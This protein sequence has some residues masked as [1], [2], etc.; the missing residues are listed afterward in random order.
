ME[1]KLPTNNLTEMFNPQERSPATTLTSPEARRLINETAAAISDDS[2][3][4][5]WVNTDTEN[6]DNDDWCIAE[7]GN[8]L[9]LN[10]NPTEVLY[11]SA[12]SGNNDD[13]AAH[14][15][16][17]TTLEV[18]SRGTLSEFCSGSDTLRSLTLSEAKQLKEAASAALAYHRSASTSQLS[19]VPSESTLRN[20]V[21]TALR[22]KL[23]SSP[24]LANY[25]EQHHRPTSTLKPNRSSGGF[26]GFASLLDL[27]DAMEEHPTILPEENSME[28]KATGTDGEFLYKNRFAAA[29]RDGKLFHPFLPQPTEEEEL[30]R[31]KYV[32]S[33]ANSQGGSFDDC[34]E[35]EIAPVL[36]CSEVSEENRIT[37]RKK[38]EMETT[39]AHHRFVICADTQF[40]ILMDG[41]PMETPNWDKEMDISLRAVAKINSMDPPPRFV[42]VCGDLV[43]TEAS[44]H[45]G[46]KKKALPSWKKML[47]RKECDDIQEQQN[48]DFQRIWSDLK[49]SIALVCLCGNHDVGNRPTVG[50]VGRFNKFFGDDYLGFWT[51]GTYNIMLNNCLFFDPSGAPELYD[52]QLHWLQDRLVYADRHGAGHI[53]VYGHY[54]WFL[55]DEEENMD[56]VTSRSVPPE[57]WGPPGVEFPDFYFHIKKKQRSVALQLFKKYNVKACFS[58]HFHQNLIS[59]TSWGMDMIV[60]GPLSMMLHSD[61]DAATDSDGLGVRVVDVS[62][63][64]FSHKFI[65]L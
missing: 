34:Y 41:T 51:N 6:D 42:T 36:L 58:G 31:R 33:Q 38:S 29:Q 28:E 18:S 21:A 2:Y 62:R 5:S 11:R 45:V 65:S 55:Y 47:S 53:F 20:N 24:H 15:F 14:Y 9:A 54:P 30:E 7:N 49:E 23:S 25:N 27:R 57:G 17:N 26:S 19:A 60:T 13:D 35:D 43:D 40:G 52:K 4:I 61:S 3:N 64:G 50:S 48:R 22:K 12:S 63:D 59:K 1:S 10:N 46:K 8:P 56:T 16:S 44:F 32:R 39:A 37:N